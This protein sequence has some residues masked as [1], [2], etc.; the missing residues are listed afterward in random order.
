M[1]ARALLV[2]GLAAGLAA[3]VVAFVVAFTIGEP[4]V[5][6]GIDVE[7]AHATSMTHHE[8]APEVSRDTQRTWGLLT[9][10]LGVG[11]A[12]GGL[13]GL[14]SAGVVG[15]VG[16]LSP[17]QSTALVVLV[18]WLALSLVPFL[19]YPA[20]PPGA[21]DAGTIGVRTAA[22]FGFLL[23][24]VLAAAAAATLG[25]RVLRTSGA[26]AAVL[27][28]AVGYLAVVVVAALLMP[29]AESVGS[30]PAD[31]LWQFRRASLLT[32]AALWATLGLVLA[33][34]VG[35]IHGRERAVAARRELAASL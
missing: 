2:R 15:R 23:V 8:E 35:R 28:A 26:Y 12:L 27:A 25:A 20:S 16:R 7:E 6:A 34:L 10:T 29:A 17:G 22:Y 3:G 11:L 1:T 32:N 31:T 19:K 9:G 21:S 4:P 18:G 30:F 24:S 33:G 14:V 5:Q 13:A